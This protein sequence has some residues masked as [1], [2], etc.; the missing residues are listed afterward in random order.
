MLALTCAA[1]L[2]GCTSSAWQ[3]AYEG[4]Q[5]ARLRE[6]T[7]EARARVVIR[8]V[9]WERIEQV[10]RELQAEVAAS[11]THPDEWPADRREAVR[12][13]LLRGLQ[14]SESASAID[15]LGRSEFSSTDTVRP[16]DGSLAEWAARI[17]ASRV[18]WSSRYVG[19][20]DKIVSEP[21]WTH[22]S[23]SDSF[24]RASGRR[25]WSSYSENSTTWVPV[26]VQADQTAWVAYFLRER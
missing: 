21:V 2:T 4:E 26:V 16:D 6:A 18:V 1:W 22:T 9:P 10:R 12:A 7:P 13:K 25:R 17:G 5:P 14:V 24:P 15:I 11:D 8:E 20:A 3:S 23:G 19:K